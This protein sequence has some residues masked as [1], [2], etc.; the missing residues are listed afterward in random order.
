EAARAEYLAAEAARRGVLLTLVA[1]VAQAYFELLELDRELGITQGTTITFQDTLDLF[2]RRYVG[3]I[4]TLL[5]VS[6]AQAALTQ[7]RAGI[8][9]LEGQIVVKENQLSTLLGRPPSYVVRAAPA[10]E[11]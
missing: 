11:S 1:D 10:G 8:P 3:G 6:R 5:E 9:E 4:G 7:A 2:R